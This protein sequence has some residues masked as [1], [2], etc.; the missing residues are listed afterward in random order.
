MK[1][2]SKMQTLEHLVMKVLEVRVNF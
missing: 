1:R 2:A